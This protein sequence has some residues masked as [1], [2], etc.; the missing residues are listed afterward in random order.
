MYMSAVTATGHKETLYYNDGVTKA[1]SSGQALKSFKVH[2]S[3]SKR[4]HSAFAV[5][6]VV[7]SPLMCSVHL[8]ILPP[9]IKEKVKKKNPSDWSNPGSYDSGPKGSESLYSSHHAGDSVRY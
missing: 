6:A 4:G 2:P 8:K 3:Q 1:H 9:G 5:K 7:A